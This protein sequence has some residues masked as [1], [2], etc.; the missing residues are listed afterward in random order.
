MWT[1]IDILYESN[2]E[3]PEQGILPVASR[4]LQIEHQLLEWQAAL[5]PLLSLITPGEVRNSDEYSLDRRFR[6]ILTLR[7]HNIRILAHRRMLDLYLASIER[8]QNYDAE[9]SMLRQVGERSKNICIQSASDLISIVHTVTHSPEPKKGLLGAWW[10]TLYYSEYSISG[11]TPAFLSVADSIDHQLSTLPSLLWPSC[12][13]ITPIIAQGNLPFMEAIAYRTK[14]LWQ[15]SNKQCPAYHL[16]T[17][18]TKWPT[19]APSLQT[20]STSVSCS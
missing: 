9:D 2:I 15:R 18:R 5:P 19:N 12:Y 16:L 4:V 14:P 6:V 13:V 7:Y 11:T 8:G 10:F 3:Y 17:R 20:P 1:V